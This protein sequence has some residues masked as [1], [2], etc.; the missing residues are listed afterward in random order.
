MP[1]DMNREAR[2]LR[3][4]LSDRGLT[5]LRVTKRGKALTIVSGPEHDPDPEARLVAARSTP[6][7]RTLGPDP[8]GGRPGRDGRHSG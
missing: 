8:V 2:T 4:I 7:Q 1:V 5:H 6:P 3:S